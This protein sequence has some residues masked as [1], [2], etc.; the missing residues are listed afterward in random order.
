MKPGRIADH[1]GTEARRRAGGLATEPRRQ[2][3]R[4]GEFSWGNFEKHHRGNTPPNEWST[5]STLSIRRLEP[6]GH[7]ARA[8]EA[9]ARVGARL[10]DRT[11]ADRYQHASIDR[12]RGSHALW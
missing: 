6:L 1:A 7:H 11:P 10:K 2:R 5:M 9:V 8:T 4:V 3:E 12:Q